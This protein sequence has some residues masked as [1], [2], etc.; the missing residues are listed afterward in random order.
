MKRHSLLGNEGVPKTRTL[1]DVALGKERADLAVV[2]GTLLNVYT[3]E[4]IE[5]QAILVKGEWIA[6]VGPHLPDA[7]GPDTSI[8]DARGKAV[9]PGLIEGHTHLADCLYSPV[10]FLRHAM[11]GGTT[12]IVTETIEPFPIRGADGIV[13]FMEA[14]QGQPIKVFGT[15][16]PLVSNSSLCNGIP[17][18]ALRTLL[19]RDDII[20]LGEAYWQGVLQNPGVFLPD[21]E[22]TLLSGRKVEGHSAGAKGRVLAAYVNTGVSSCHEPTK[23]AETLERLRMG[24]H[25]MVREGSIRSD[26]AALAGLSDAGIDFRRMILVTDGMKPVDLL[27][28]GYMEYVVQ[29]GVDSGLD[30][31]KAIQMATINVADYFGLD[32]LVGGIAPGRQADILLLPGKGTIYPETV[33]SKGRVIARNGKVVVPPRE[34]AFRPGNLNS[35]VLPGAMTPADF[36]IPV[37]GGRSEVKVRV[38]E[39]IT[40][41][42]TREVVLSLSVKDGGVRSDPGRDLLKVAAVERSLVPGKTF[43]GLVRGFGLKEGA[44]GCSSAWDTSDIIVVG[45]ND[46]DMADVVNRI[47]ALRGGLVLCA[48]GRVLAEIPLPIFGLMSDLPLPELARKMKELSEKAKSLGFAFDDPHR[49]LIPLTGAAIPFIRLSEEGLKDIKT[50][51]ALPLFV[52]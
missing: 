28:K 23:P 31:V 50:G 36:A 4:W 52:E 48:G 26:L 43:V 37:H 20:G 19:A 3:G 35:V 27:E 21:F 22:E 24:L 40:D 5:D 8:I 2:N 18:E 9:I 13:D 51:K 45:A 49:T 47:H 30:P 6:Y 14:F 46:K 44:V 34:H 42:V 17:R 29:R 33:I 12:T 15:A 32:G 39:Q 25:V 10:E 16:P 38:I 11:A 7:V 41:L 1:M